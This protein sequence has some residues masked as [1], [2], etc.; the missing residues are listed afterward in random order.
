MLRERGS[1]NNILET[2]ETLHNRKYSSFPIFRFHRFH[3]TL[4]LK[5]FVPFKP[6]SLLSVV[7]MIAASSFIPF[8]PF[9]VFIH[10]EQIKGFS[11]CRL[12]SSSK[13]FKIQVSFFIDAKVCFFYSS[14]V[15]M[16]SVKSCTAHP[17]R[18]IYSQHHYTFQLWH[19]QQY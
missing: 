12:S 14:F 4:F 16:C 3:R 17:L 19:A 18:K 11:Y 5:L 9:N 10:L 7:E 15:C 13:Q 2:L 8:N 1:S 6:S